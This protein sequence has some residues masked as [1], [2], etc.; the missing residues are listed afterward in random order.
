MSKVN[1]KKIR[2]RVTKMNTAWKQSAAPVAFKGI[3][4]PDFK[5]RIQAA[6]AVDQQYADLL[7]QARMKA[8]E[9]DGLYQT[10]ATIQSTLATGSKDMRTSN[11]II[12]CMKRWASPACPNGNQG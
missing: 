12:R 8:D 4:Q 11:P 5:S 9:R 1:S 7:A 3:K 6:A 10:S 2:E